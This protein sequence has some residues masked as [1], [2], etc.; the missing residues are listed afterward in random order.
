MGIY[1][2]K[3]PS[4]S[5]WRVMWDQYTNTLT[6]NIRKD[7]KLPVQ[8]CRAMM[9]D[10]Y[11]LTKKML[12]GDR[13]IKVKMVFAAKEEPQAGIVLTDAPQPKDEVTLYSEGGRVVTHYSTL[14][15]LPPPEY[16]F[17]MEKRSDFIQCGLQ[18]TEGKTRNSIEICF[19]VRHHTQLADGAIKP[20][21]EPD[22]LD[23]LFTLHMHDNQLLTK[24][25][26]VELFDHFGIDPTSPPNNLMA[27]LARSARVNA[28][29]SLEDDDQPVNDAVS[30]ILKERIIEPRVDKK[31]PHMRN[32]SANNLPR[33]R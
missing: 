32:S 19:P 17:E 29:K 26:F 18:I 27:P 5:I 7:K 4:C 6:L 14:D 2:I 24:T 3:D 31:N 22:L 20:I 25:G 23:V 30:R 28:G 33:S 8:Q 1:N 12:N 16:V 21:L 11:E 15:S 10:G 9:E 13:Y